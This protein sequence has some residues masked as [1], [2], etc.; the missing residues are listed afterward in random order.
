MLDDFLLRAFL[1]GLGV[2]LVAGPLGCFIVWRRMAYFG[3]ALAHAGFLGIA[4]GLLLGFDPI[5]GVAVTGSVLAVGL[6][7]LQ[8]RRVLSGDTALGLLAHAGLAMGLVLLSFLQFLRIDLLSYLFGDLLAVSRQDLALIWGGGALVLLA[9]AAIWRPLLR[10]TL[11]EELAAAEGV[12]VVAVQ[13]AFLV[14]LA[15]VVAVAMKVVGILL[16]TALLIL[17]AATARRLSPTPEAMA[18]LAAVYG[19]LAVGG[20]LWA[21]WRWDTP[22]GPSIVVTALLL[23]VATQLLPRRLIR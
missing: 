1:G 13:L 6:L 10:V 5:L 8:R 15:I 18:L 23:F 21:S 7:T 16:I 22:S 17:P 12:P 4:L 20:G 3:D 11:H 2:A 14:L 19:A 9:L